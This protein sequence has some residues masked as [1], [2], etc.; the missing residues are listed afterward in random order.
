MLDEFCS[1][2]D[3]IRRLSEDLGKGILRE[4]TRNLNHNQWTKSFDAGDDLL[5]KLNLACVMFLQGLPRARAASLLLS[6]GSDE[7]AITSYTLTAKCLKKLAKLY[8]IPS[9]RGF[10]PEAEKVGDLFEVLKTWLKREHLRI[11]SAQAVA[12]GGDSLASMMDGVQAIAEAA[13]RANP[14]TARLWLATQ[15]QI[16]G[17]QDWVVTWFQSTFNA[18]EKE[19]TTSHLSAIRASAAAGSAAVV[20]KAIEG[21]ISLEKRRHSAPNGSINTL[22][23]STIN[24]G[25]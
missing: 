25:S 19:N 13:Q 23:V 1:E 18:A 22:G 2:K 24:N 8:A 17:G 9:S 15:A 7:A 5:R 3:N 10:D 21:S 12:V 16:S 20:N 6:L 4:L 14:D 11:T